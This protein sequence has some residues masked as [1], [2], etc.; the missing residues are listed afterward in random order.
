M[1][2]RLTT[3]AAAVLLGAFSGTVSAASLRS[4]SLSSDSASV[5]VYASEED[6]HEKM[7]GDDDDF[8]YHGNDD[9]DDDDYEC[10]NVFANLKHNALQNYKNSPD[11]KATGY[12]SCTLCSGGG[13]NPKVTCNDALVTN[14][15]TTVIVSHFHFCTDLSHD[16]ETCGGPPVINCCG[17]NGTGIDPAP[18]YIKKCAETDT[19]T[20][21]AAI[22][23]MMCQVVD[24]ENIPVTQSMTASQRIQDIKKNPHQYYFNFH[25]R[26]SWA[27]WAPGDPKG[28]CRGRIE[29]FP[30]SSTAVEM[31]RELGDE[32]K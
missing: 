8:H 11:M 13:R 25:S 7:P 22:G 14:L 20:H 10:F 17:T 5:D 1:K 28:M 9:Y 15:Y 16:G 27:H 6:T 18:G 19:T 32:E 21:M 31:E 26:S 30:S 4:A 29:L 3:S 2:L 24:D 23:D 12:T